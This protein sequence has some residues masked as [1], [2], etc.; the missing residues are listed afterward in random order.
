M[1]GATLAL[2]P[3]C[4]YSSVS[5]P[6]LQWRAGQVRAGGTAAQSCLSNKPPAAASCQNQRNFHTSWPTWFPVFVDFFS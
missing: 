2:T 6:S 3:G 4:R 1:S 5:P